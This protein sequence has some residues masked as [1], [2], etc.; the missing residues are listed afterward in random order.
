MVVIVCSG[1]EGNQPERL[2]AEGVS[3]SALSRGLSVSATPG[4]L[5]SPRKGG[6]ESSRYGS[7]FSRSS[8]NGGA[9]RY[10]GFRFATPPAKSHSL[11]SGFR[12]FRSCCG[13]R[14]VL[15]QIYTDL[16]T[17]FHN[18]VF[19]R[20]LFVLICGVYSALWW[21]LTRIIVDFHCG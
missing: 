8:H 1:A 9:S 13:W 10:R 21:F 6:R 20:T 2:N 7:R 18:I 17:D 5:S 12:P 4:I 11:R 19:I 14:V 3:P 15:T 16:C